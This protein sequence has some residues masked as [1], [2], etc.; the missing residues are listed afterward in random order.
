MQLRG[1][2]E[3]EIAKLFGKSVT[4]LTLEL[5]RLLEHCEQLFA[6]QNT[7]DSDLK[8]VASENEVCRR[9]MQIPG[10]GPI[11]ALTFYSAVGEPDRFARLTDIGSYFGLTPRLHQSGL[12]ERSGRISKMGNKAARTILVNSSLHFMKYSPADCELRNWASR[13]ES[14]RGR[15]KAKVAL[16]RKLA[17]IMLAMWKTGDP[18]SPGCRMV[19][20][21]A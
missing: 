3:A 2:V 11:C 10:V 18:Y 1:L 7:I 21:Q 15:G 14:R 13:I 19:P 16:A 4:P 20:S 8:R 5:H 12:T 9:F 17:I 6:H